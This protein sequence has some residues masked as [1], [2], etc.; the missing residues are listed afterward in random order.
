MA[1]ERGTEKISTASVRML[2]ANI[3]ESNDREL[4]IK[5]CRFVYNQKVRHSQE[6]LH[7][8][9]SAMRGNASEPYALAPLNA[10]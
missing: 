1:P 8:P 9:Q 2:A 5:R 3:Y 7:V 4:T 10:R 6:K